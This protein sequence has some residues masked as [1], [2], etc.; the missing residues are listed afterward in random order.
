MASI[1]HIRN[2][3]IDKLLSIKNKEFLIALEGIVSNSNTEND[4]IELTNEQKIMLE[5]S[6][7]DIEN[8]RVITHEALKRKTSEWLSGKS[9]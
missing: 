4:I 8:G 1:D 7:Q 2:S 6:D 3:L 9:S 5:M